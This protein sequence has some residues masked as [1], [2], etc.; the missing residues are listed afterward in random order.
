MKHPFN[1]PLLCTQIGRRGVLLKKHR[2]TFC[3]FFWSCSWLYNYILQK[4]TISNCNL[5]K[6]NVYFIEIRQYNYKDGAMSYIYYI[7]NVQCRVLRQ[8]GFAYTYGALHSP[9]PSVRCTLPS[10][11]L[12]RPLGVW[13]SRP[14]L[15]VPP[16]P[17]S[18]CS[19]GLRVSV[20]LK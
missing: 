4:C 19:A 8:N 14:H 7:L 3:E 2:L 5:D 13:Y 17:S 20:N 9:S 1:I 16:V 18:H 12:E 6:L 11:P 10:W 15:G